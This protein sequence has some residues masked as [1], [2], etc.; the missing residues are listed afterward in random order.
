ML[1]TVLAYQHQAHS[2]RAQY[3]LKTH[4]LF[5]H[6]LLV[7]GK[8]LFRHFY[9]FQMPSMVRR[10]I[11]DGNRHLHRVSSQNKVSSKVKPY[12][13][14]CGHR[15]CQAGIELATALSGGCDQA[16]VR[17]T[18][19]C[20]GVPLTTWAETRL[21]EE[22]MSLTSGISGCGVIL[23]VSLF[24]VVTY[25]QQHVMLVCLVTAAKRLGFI[26][27]ATPGSDQRP[28]K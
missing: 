7:L 12:T 14:R 27:I 15:N 2:M 19:E 3:L 25:L 1:Q 16:W 10:R 8:H 11:R 28:L 13:R 26:S 6:A 9:S 23:V 18:K 17:A 5:H 21:V 24:P 4:F 20:C 22:C